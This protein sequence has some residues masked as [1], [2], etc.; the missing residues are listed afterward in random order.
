VAVEV[1][2]WELDI[3]RRVL[4]EEGRMDGKRRRRKDEF[5]EIFGR[6]FWEERI[7][8]QELRAFWLVFA[9][10]LPLR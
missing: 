4:L 6:E 5:G 1:G 2:S 9:D 3:G 10:F 7:F 8:L